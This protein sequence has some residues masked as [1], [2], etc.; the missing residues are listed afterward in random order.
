MYPE[1]IA[2]LERDVERRRDPV[3]LSN[4]ASVYGLAGRKPEAVKL[5]DELKERSQEHSVSDAVFV[6]AYIGLGEKDEA[7]A[8]LE[9]AFEEHDH[10]MVDIKS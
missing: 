3:P 2:A 7:M 9:R 1:A 6:A 5:L 4:L 10:W 8:R